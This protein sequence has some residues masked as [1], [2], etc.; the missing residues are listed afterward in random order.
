V[1]VIEINTKI[2][3][4][5]SKVG[6]LGGFFTKKSPFRE[7]FHQKVPVFGDFLVKKLP[8]VHVKPFFV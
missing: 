6:H 2:K 5:Q 7:I 4:M 3:Q 8:T 1:I